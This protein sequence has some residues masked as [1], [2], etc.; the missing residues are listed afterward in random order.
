MLLNL[1]I[2]RIFLKTHLSV[3]N[4]YFLDTYY[5]DVHKAMG[6]TFFKEKRFCLSKMPR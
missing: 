1:G 4:D 6:I 2:Y 5:V 3:S